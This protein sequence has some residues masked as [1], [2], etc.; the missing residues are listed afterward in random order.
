MSGPGARLRRKVCQL[1]PVLVTTTLLA[2]SAPVLRAQQSAAR[3]DSVAERMERLVV[4]GTATRGD[5]LRFLAE[6]PLSLKVEDALVR[7]AED[8]MKSGDRGAARRHLEV[9]VRDHLVSDRGAKAAQQLAQMMFDEGSALAGCVVL[10]SARA[11][12]SSSNVELE[13][14]IVY[15]GRRCEQAR[16]AAERDSGAK[17]KRDSAAAAA[18]ATPPPT[19]KP[20]KGA[21]SKAASATPIRSPAPAPAPA[22]AADR[23]WSAQVAAYTVRGD[24]LRLEA[25]LKAR[26]Y[27]VRIVGDKPY[28]IRIGRFALRDSAVAIVTKLKTEKT[29]AIVVAAEQP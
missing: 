24:A 4:S 18:A 6:Y 26:G 16:D 15:A 9:L 8:E 19:A 17:A 13:N 3:P 10:D 12:V 29:A 25:K 1:G 22:P 5:L 2:A 7:L 21:P 20:A 23:R 28:R 14:Q 27:D 11:H